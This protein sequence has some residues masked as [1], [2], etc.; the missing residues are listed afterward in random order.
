MNFPR[1]PEPFTRNNETKAA[2]EIKTPSLVQAPNTILLQVDERPMIGVDISSDIVSDVWGHVKRRTIKLPN[3]KV[4]MLASDATG[5]L[6]PRQAIWSITYDSPPQ[7]GN[8][9][10]RP[11]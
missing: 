9:V 3:G 8:A 5:E 6:H 11:S 4:A 1:P 7:V 2:V 10:L